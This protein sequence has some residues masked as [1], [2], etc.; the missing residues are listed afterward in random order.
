MPEF[1]LALRILLIGVLVVAGVGKVRS[2]AAFQAAAD[3]LPAAALSLP[4][5]LGPRVL[6]TLLVAAELITAGALVLW[7]SAIGFALSTAL[8]LV[9]TSSLAK[10]VHDGADAR[11]R[12]FGTDSGVLSGRHVVRAAAL[13][14]AGA[15]G[16]IL[17]TVAHPGLPVTMTGAGAAVGGVMAATVIINWDLLVYLR[18]PAAAS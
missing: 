14:A 17:Q 7:T 16:W 9:M 8:F 5:W 11:C 2:S 1:V 10:L 15:L 13:M 18:T 3:S 6:A 12:C 4:G